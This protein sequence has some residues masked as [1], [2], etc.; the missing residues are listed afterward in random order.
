[1]R[2]AVVALALLGFIFFAVKNTFNAYVLWG[3]AGLASLGTYVY[4]P[5]ASIPYVMLFAA[6]TLVSVVLRRQLDMTAQGIMPIGGLV[7]LLFLICFHGFLCALF[8]YAGTGRNW[9]MW[10]D[11]AKTITFCLMMPLMVNSRARVVVL[12]TAIVLA[13]GTRGIVDGA[14]SIVS[15]GAHNASGIVGVAD[16]NHYAMMLLMMMP[17]VYTLFSHASHRLVRLGWL[18]MLGFIA[19]AV[20]ATNSRGGLIGLTVFTAWMLLISRHK[21]GGFFLILAVVLVLSQIVPESWYQRMETIKEANEDDSFMGRVAAWKISSA[22]ALAHPIFGG[23]YRAIQSYEV[24]DRFKYSQGFMGFVE[25]PVLNSSAVAA[26]SIWFEVVADQGF[27]GLGLFV[28]LILSSLYYWRKVR[29]LARKNMQQVHWAF[30]LA[31]ALAGCVAIYVITGSA[32]SAAYF[33]LP[34]ILMMLM[35]VVYLVALKEV[36]ASHLPA[37]ATASSSSSSSN[38]RTAKR[39]AT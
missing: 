19:L 31:N 29:L 38:A 14:K 39:G 37:T 13:I 5:M 32:L 6:I 3:W 4:G 33:E 15:L 24:W 20:V 1:M 27:V 18:G 25:T 9:E 2:D 30:D 17:L 26:H 8:A 35:G 12:V 10:G 22:I 21:V 16:N 28:L 7:L 34:Y 36:K 23:G 11:M